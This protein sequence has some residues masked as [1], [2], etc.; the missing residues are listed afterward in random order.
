[1]ENFLRSRNWGRIAAAAGIDTP[2]KSQGPF[3]NHPVTVDP[4]AIQDIRAVETI[5]EGESIDRRA[6]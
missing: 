6:E 4:M 5:Q 2:T 1:M 3:M